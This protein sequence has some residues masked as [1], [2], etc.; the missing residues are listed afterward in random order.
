MILRKLL[1]FALVA[2]LSLPAQVQAQGI[3]GRARTYLSY[4]Q[5]RD[6]VLDSVPEGG[7]SGEGTQRA[8][9]N[10]TP[11]SCGDA[12]CQF[13]RSGPEASVVPL[14]QDLELNVWTGITGLRAYAHVRVREPLGDLEIWPRSQERFEA[15][16]AYVEYGRSFYRIQA[17]RKWETTA[18][19]FYGIDFGAAMSLNVL[20]H[21]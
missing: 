7:V 18:L 12:Y 6:L 20:E 9:S 19:G 14:L 16:A 8:L 10:G 3:N 11:A 5:V 15:L 21:R 13:Y 17:G 1:L 4:I 2:L